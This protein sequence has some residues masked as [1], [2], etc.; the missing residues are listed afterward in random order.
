MT[1]ATFDQAPAD[2]RPAPRRIQ[3]L[4]FPVLPSGALLAQFA[5]FGAGAVGLYLT[6]GLAV[7]L[8]VAGVVTAGLGML[9]EGGRI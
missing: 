3:G 9:R 7:S 6:A 5:G 4:R 8:L 1:A 2:A